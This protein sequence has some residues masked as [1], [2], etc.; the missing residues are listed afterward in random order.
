MWRP[1]L[2]F[3]GAGGGGGGGWAEGSSGARFWCMGLGFRVQGVHLEAIC[4]IKLRLTLTLNPKP[5]TLNPK[6]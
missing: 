5:E 2:Q 1:T 6:P 4:A 3:L